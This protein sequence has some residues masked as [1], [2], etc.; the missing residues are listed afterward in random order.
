M[1]C[2]RIYVLGGGDYDPDYLGYND[3]WS[4]ED[5]IHWVQE[6]DKAK[7]HER[8]WFSSVVYKGHIW[9]LGGWS[10][11]PYKNWSDMWYSK[12]GKVWKEFQSRVPMWKERHEHSAFVFKN[13]IW[14]AGGMTPPLVNDVWS[15][16]LPDD[17]TGE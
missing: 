10:N 1:G 7:W 13:K 9:V 17:W 16:K 8:I 3:A 15:L 4:S 14:I 5:G 2:L 6:T 11:H 12:D